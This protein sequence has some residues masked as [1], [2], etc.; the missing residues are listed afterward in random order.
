MAIWNT[1]FA[2]LGLALVMLR[3]ADFLAQWRGLHGNQQI[4]AKWKMIPSSLRL[5]LWRE[6][7]ER[8]FE[9]HEWSMDELSI[10]CFNTLFHWTIVI[11]F[12]GLNIHYFLVTTANHDQVLLLYMSHAHGLC[13]S[14]LNIN[15]LFTNKKKIPSPSL[16]RN[17]IIATSKASD[18][19]F[20]SCVISK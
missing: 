17:N 7:N 14:F 15:L 5:C 3:Q 19:R 6:M 16:K 18:K 13:I 12:N 9:D 8:N 4:A 1:F 11:S 20:L 10:F 2:R